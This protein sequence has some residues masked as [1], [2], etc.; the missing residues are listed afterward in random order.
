[1]SFSV[2]LVAK[3]SDPRLQATYA[4]LESNCRDIVVVDGADR[5]EALTRALRKAKHATVLVLEAGDTVEPS[6][7]A[8]LEAFGA[9]APLGAICITHVQ[10]AEVTREVTVRVAR[11]DGARFEGKVTGRLLHAEEGVETLAVVVRAARVRA[12]E[13]ERLRALSAEAQEHPQDGYILY[14]LAEALVARGPA[15][16][17]EQANAALA[18]L[19][20]DTVDAQ[21][22]VLTLASALARLDMHGELLQLAEACRDRWPHFTELRYREALAHQKLARVHEMLRAFEDCLK[23]G[24]DPT[25]PGTVGAGTFLPWY[26]LGLFAE[27]QGDRAG[28][29]LSYGRA[30]GFA[31]YGPAK[32]RLEEI[33]RAAVREAKVPQ[34]LT[35]DGAVAEKDC[36][37]GRIAYPVNDSFVGRSLDL[38]GEWCEAEIDLFASLIEPGSVVVDVGA[39][40]GSHT[41]FFAR[42]VGPTGRVVA[43]EPQSFV[44]ELLVR[45]VRANRFTNVDC[46]RKAATD[47]PM[48]VH[49]PKVDPNTTCNFGAIA[50]TTSTEPSETEAV[51]AVPLDTLGLEACD[52]LK[53]D[54]EGLE[55]RVLAGA[56]RMISRFLPVIFVEN[57]TVGRSREILETIFALGYRAYWHVAPYYRKANYFHNEEN[58]FSPYQPEAN[59]VCVP[60]GRTLPGLVEASGPDDDFVQALARGAADG[61]YRPSPRSG[62]SITS[63]AFG[64]AAAAASSGESSAPGP[65]S[66]R[67]TEMPSALLTVMPSAVTSP[68]SAIA[69]PR[70]PA[71]RRPLTI[72]ACIPGRE[73]SGRFF[74]A[75]NEFV[76]KCHLIGV[77]LVVSRRY[78]AV[79]Y[80]AR[81]KVA[82]GDVRRGAKQAPWGGELDYD[83]ML[84]IDS[85]V[86]FRFED[87]Q[88]LLAHK[89][90]MVAGLYLMSD[91]AR[92]A[93]VER[94]DEAV[95]AAAGEFEF[96]T[97][98]KVAGRQGLLPVDYC[99]FGFVLVRKGV[100]EKLEYPWFRPL[101]LELGGVSEFT[102]EDVGFCLMAKR[103]G[104]KMF[105]DPNV[106]VGHE[107]TVVF[108]PKKAA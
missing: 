75:W 89:V 55:T 58:V 107:K 81:N 29:R 38:Y 90:D 9:T 2:L 31:P 15:E 92:F 17:L 42:Q 19:P 24:E 18:Y 65:G 7:F 95:F 102:A 40:V 39:N 88:A 78:D 62:L 93:A 98:A 6:S 71:P 91:N 14:R 12:V 21:G 80:Y 35:D 101:Y 28:A 73:F 27:A 13:N 16:A 23:L 84:W 97:P 44:H 20:L 11:K 8:A 49:L 10:D 57:N 85:D 83:Y 108:E 41:V 50:V 70:A 52:F 60:A 4:S 87:F 36:R 64:S 104:M 67:P 77:K 22:L 106:V 68:A 66:E 72:V 30:L 54:V 32:K 45:N 63:R 37:H 69:V 48:T 3:S 56:K 79:V 43:L 47:S 5:A 61:V 53:I 100:F 96:L 74:D 34:R 25:G 103:A 46:V 105:V 82:G 59:L 1:L 94:M 86:L 99:G 26:Q 76:E 33:D 51:A